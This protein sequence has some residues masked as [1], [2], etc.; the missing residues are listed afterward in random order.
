MVVEAVFSRGARVAQRME[1]LIQQTTTS[2]DA[3]LYRFNNPRLAQALAKASARGVSVRIILDAGK[4]GDDLVTRR[5]CADLRFSFRLSH[6][7]QGPGSKMHHKFAILDARMVL[8]GS[9]NWTAESE[10]ENFENLLVVTDPALAD[11]YRE[12]FN[13]LWNEAEKNA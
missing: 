7:V 2:L 6:G 1:R 4:Y 11:R 5:L 13:A 8:S 3:A 12:E 10:E 9:Y